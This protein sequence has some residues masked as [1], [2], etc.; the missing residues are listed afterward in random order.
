MPESLENKTEDEEAIAERVK[1][2]ITLVKRHNG[3]GVL[4]RSSKT[5]K[6]HFGIIDFNDAADRMGFFNTLIPPEKQI[7]KHNYSEVLEIYR[8][9]KYRQLL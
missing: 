5:G 2:V 6:Y 8:V 3:K 9:H 7:G 4:I 1:K